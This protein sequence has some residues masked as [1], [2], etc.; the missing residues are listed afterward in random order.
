[1]IVMIGIR[2]VVM[3]IIMKMMVKRLWQ[4]WD[5]GALPIIMN[6]S[7]CGGHLDEDQEGHV[8]SNAGSGP[9][10]VRDGGAHEPRVLVAP[11]LHVAQ[12]H[13]PEDVAHRA[14]AAVAERR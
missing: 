14:A 13:R 1:M 4:L 9:L 11:G 12:R 6:D 8:L 5:P 2:M 10:D 3:L 7:D